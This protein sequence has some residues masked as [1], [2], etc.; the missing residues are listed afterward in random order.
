MKPNN[1]LMD[2]HFYICKIYKNEPYETANVMV[3]EAIWLGKNSLPIPD[4]ITEIQKK[5]INSLR[6]FYFQNSPKFWEGQI[7][8]AKN[9]LEFVGYEI[10]ASKIISSSKLP[11]FL[12]K[13]KNENEYEVTA[14]G[15]WGFTQPSGKFSSF[16]EAVEFYNRHN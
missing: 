8:I 11:F 15:S 3:R 13:E 5:I 12:M 14:Y 9:F 10:M 4:H 1:I 7:T 2:A 16:E 6:K